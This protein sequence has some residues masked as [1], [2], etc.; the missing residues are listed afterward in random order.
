VFEE[1]A[2]KGL[3]EKV[4]T[5]LAGL[6]GTLACFGLAWGLGKIFI[7]QDPDRSSDSEQS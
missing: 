7:P 6:I 4:A 1:Y 2:V 3:P 5:P